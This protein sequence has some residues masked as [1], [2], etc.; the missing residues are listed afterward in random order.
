STTLEGGSVIPLTVNGIS[1]PWASK[2]WTA[3]APSSVHDTPVRFPKTIEPVNWPPVAAPLPVKTALSWS[4]RQTCVPG[5]I[6][7]GLGVGSSIDTGLLA[8]QGTGV[9]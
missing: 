6:G 2:S 4:A 7:V 9:G 8:I 5:G 3:G 1:F